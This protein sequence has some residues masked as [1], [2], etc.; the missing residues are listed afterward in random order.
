MFIPTDS[1]T[2]HP[3]LGVIST[4]D[5]DITCCLGH[6][7]RG[8]KFGQREEKEKKVVNGLLTCF[9]FI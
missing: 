6:P 4:Q 7:Y 8:R 5:F 1:A 3:A 2:Y 9:V